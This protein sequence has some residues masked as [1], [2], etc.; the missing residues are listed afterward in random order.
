MTYLNKVVCGI[1]ALVCCVPGVISTLVLFDLMSQ[2]ED[3]RCLRGSS[4][5]SR[6]VAESYD[7]HIFISKQNH[8]TPLYW[9]MEREMIPCCLATGVH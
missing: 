8:C 6:N 9:L 2:A 7:W 3:N 1:L 4:K 5:H